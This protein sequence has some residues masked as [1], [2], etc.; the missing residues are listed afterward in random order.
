MASVPFNNLITFSRGS[1]ATLT[2][3][4]GLIQYAPNNF[5]TFS[6]QFNSVPWESGIAGTG[7][8]NTVTSNAGV[9]PDGTSTADRVQFSLGGG[10][11]TA[12]LTRRR[13]QPTV[14]LDTV[15]FS[16]WIRSFDGTSTYNMHL[17]DAANQTRNI[18]V[19]GTWTRFAV[20]AVYTATA[21]IGLGLRGGQSPANS[22]TADVLVWGAQLELGSTATTYNPT[23][24]KN[25]LGFSEAFDNAA[26]TK[27]GSSIVT[28]AQANPVNG[29]FNAQKLMEDTS[30]GQ[31]R[32]FNTTGVTYIAST[33]VCFSVYVK[34]AERSFVYVRL[35]NS[36]GDF[37][38]GFVNLTTGAITTVT[39][40]GTI[41]ATSV[42]N[43]W[44]RIAA[45]GTSAAAT[46]VSGY[47]AAATS[48]S[49]VSYTGDGNS[50][51]YIY[52]AQ[53]SDSASLDPYVPT[54]GAAPSSTAYYGPRFDYDPVT[55]AAKGIL[56]E[57][58]RVNLLTYS[59]DFTD[60]SWVALGAKNLVANSTVSPDGG[61]N[62]STLT[63]NSAVAFQGIGKTLTV[64]NDNASYTASIYVRKTT[65]GT[66]STFG[67]N[68][69]LSGGTTVV[70]NL[71][72]NTDTG[73]ILAGSG[74]VQNAGAYWR[75]SGSVTNNTTGNTSLVFQLYPATSAYNVPTDSSAATGSAIIYGAQLEAG[76][77]ATSYIPT[78]A[79]TVTR[80]A[81]VATI[82]GSLFSQWYNQTQ[83]AFVINF[84]P[85]GG[86]VSGSTRVLSTTSGSVLNRVVDVNF[87]GGN[88]TN[89]NGTAPTTI[90]A[91][92]VTTTPQR[93]AI[94]YA[95]ANYG[96]TLNGGTVV[97]DTSALVNSPT[98][99]N[100][101]YLDTGNYLNGHIRSINYFP[102][103][104][105]DFQL[106]ALTA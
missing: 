75:I 4:N 12:D 88:W 19:T 5:V 21:Y 35:N 98:R 62:A 8:A 20:S 68:F 89:Y 72:V 1:N 23:T 60:G 67:I 44:W 33:P 47:I 61:T 50:G 69:S 37:V 51:I 57:E 95:T 16:V 58:Q 53:L 9:A 80:S 84:T 41:T 101:G 82:T 39:G 102:T 38:T 42:G 59:N 32:V 27:S 26:W 15:V 63:D 54:P 78:I 65:G 93:I 91:A 3:A 31:H 46:A 40:A 103:R 85:D 18:V 70:L 14:P 22:N 11:T 43:G 71:R 7:V 24:V 96:Y 29:A 94:A 36:G 25:L 87:S 92:T 73:A 77:F 10:T 104:L 97:A 56:V 81:D 45:I 105:A 86:L 99:L 49:V 13:Q 2:G 100:L 34:A 74:T 76:A 52:G 48:G 6:E 17:Q 79:S 64:A 28:G 55:L 90:G 106:Q 83:G 66:S 30:T